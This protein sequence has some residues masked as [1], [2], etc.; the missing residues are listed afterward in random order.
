MGQQ[1]KID[2]ITLFTSKRIR[3]IQKKKVMKSCR[4]RYLAKSHFVNSSAMNQ[5]FEFVNYRGSIFTR[6]CFDKSTI[7][8]CDFWGATF[9]KCSFIGANITDCVFMACKFKNCNF[10]DTHFAYSTIVNTSL[11]ECINI[12]LQNSV[13][14][15]HSPIY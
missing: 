15:N 8:G 14:F 12:T 13:I 2:R 3:K 7:K 5:A 4:C 10:S 6:V 9:N 11:A 1:Y